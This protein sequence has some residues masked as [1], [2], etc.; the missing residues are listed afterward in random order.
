MGVVYFLYAKD[1][2]TKETRCIRNYL[3]SRAQLSRKLFVILHLERSIFCKWPNQYHK[4]IRIESNQHRK[5][6]Y[7]RTGFGRPSDAIRE[8]PFV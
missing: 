8:F 1:L 7:S 6:L 5:L 2:E 3:C 4:Y